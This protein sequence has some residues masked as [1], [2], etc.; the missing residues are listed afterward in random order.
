VLLLQFQFD[1]FAVLMAGFVL[2]IENSDM[3]TDLHASRYVRPLILWSYGQFFVLLV[4]ALVHVS[5]RALQDNE[6]DHMIEDEISHD[7]I[8]EHVQQ[9]IAIDRGV[10]FSPS[11]IAASIYRCLFV[12]RDTSS[13]IDGVREILQL[14]WCVINGLNLFA[15]WCGL[16]LCF[17]SEMDLSSSVQ[18]MILVNRVLIAHCLIGWACAL[19]LLLACVSTR[20]SKF[21]ECLTRHTLIKRNR[22]QL[23]KSRAEELACIPISIVMATSTST[24]DDDFNCTSKCSQIDG[25]CSIC[26]VDFQHGEQLRSL[27]C[28][29]HFHVDCVDAWLMRKDQATCPLCRLQVTGSFL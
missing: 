21:L 17:F 28:N 8:V 2:A 4:N 18:I 1:I 29:H 9:T 15:V 6:A 27:P 12:Q 3:T 24:A 10:V 7:F 16:R 19:C 26:L 14:I 25:M 20:F 5:L 23:L 11:L 22:G 13:L